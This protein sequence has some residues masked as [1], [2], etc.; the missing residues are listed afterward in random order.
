MRSIAVLLALSVLLIATGCNT[1]SLS[2]ERRS[3]ISTVRVVPPTVGETSYS[4]RLPRE[5]DVDTG[6]ALLRIPF[7]MPLGLA[8]ELIKYPKT[9]KKKSRQLRTIF[10]EAKV[11]VPALVMAEFLDQLRATEIFPNVVDDGEADA[12]LKLEVSYGVEGSFMG[13]EE[14]KPWLAVT[15]TLQ[16]RNGRCLWR[17]TVSVNAGNAGLRELPF[18][19]P[20][21]SSILLRRDFR[22][23]AKPA[24]EG[25]LRHL[26]GL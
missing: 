10:R 20:F 26:V 11:D 15:G 6:N 5:Y 24:V 16:D 18:P 23:A 3:S 13:R 12:I 2:P 22:N 1:I 21:D 14:W 9:K 17:R 25:L 19:D 8:Y 4:G 7:T